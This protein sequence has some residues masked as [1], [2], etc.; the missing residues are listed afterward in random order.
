MDRFFLLVVMLFSLSAFSQ[1][2]NLALDAI[3]N[4]KIEAEDPALFV[5]V[6]KDGAVIYTSIRG[7]VSLQHKVEANEDSRS[8]IAS[9]AK[10][11]TALMILDLFLKEKL[12][13][14]DDIRKYLPDLYPKVKEAIKIRHLIN[15]TSGIRDYC[16]LM[17]IQQNAWWRREGLDN[18]DVIKLLAKQEDLAFAPGTDNEYSNSGYNLLAEIVELVTE[19]DFHTYSKRFFQDLGMTQ[20]SFLEDYMYV[21]PNQ[22]IP[23]SDWGDGVWQQY[24]T[25]TST[26]GEGFLFTTLND[27]LRYEQL[28]QRAEKEGNQLL[29]QSQL[30]IPNSK[31]KAYGFG[32][33]LTE[34]LN[35]KSVHHEGVTGSYS[36]QTLRFPEEKL[37]IFVMSNNSRVWSG[38]LA[39]EIASEFL[40]EK[41]VVVTYDPKLDSVPKMKLAKTF[42]GQY[43]SANGELVRVQ[44]EEGSLVWRRGNRNPLPLVKEGEN[45]YYPEYDNQ[46]KM[47]FFGDELALCYPSGETFMYDRLE[48]DEPTLADYES[49]VGK[50][51]S[52]E[53]ETSFSI[54]LEEGDL[55]FRRDGWR[56]ERKV[57]VLNRTDL[58]LRNY[59]LKVKRDQFNRVVAITLSSGRALNNRFAKKSNLQ[60]QPK[61]ET[62]GGSICVT[63]IGSV[64]GSASDILLTKN[65]ESGNEIWSQQFG[66]SSYDKASSLISTKDGYL[67]VGST[68]SYGK[69]NYD[70]FVIKTDKRGNKLWQN[71]YGESMNEYGY[72]AEVTPS[73]YLI[74][75]S[76][77]HC[78]NDV[79]DC[80]TNVW[81]VYI[82]E[83]GNELSSQIMEEL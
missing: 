41:Q 75:G 72:T 50:Y 55:I 19:E 33:E 76:I 29:I 25:M 43:Y 37:S 39:E 3:V 30:P 42:V 66:G 47:A 15:H 62:E 27:Q 6:V 79:F 53:L 70:M 57:E 22:A 46:L 69:G 8:N 83:D 58:L 14:E 61:I 9:T 31:R 7:L 20:T 24:P 1:T 18:D 56:K 59:R 80:T 64:D 36:S 10:Q 52:E 82:D 49:F 2:Q 78:E 40:P 34:R 32:V 12:S 4:S 73:G 23:Y 28:L 81:T 63:T 45:L 51:Y 5:G 77:Q 68:S 67:I 74:K 26:Y 17:G 13:L 21:I 35:Y 71:T 16:D 38:G 48:A 60:F 11:F 44:E 65:Y 54:S